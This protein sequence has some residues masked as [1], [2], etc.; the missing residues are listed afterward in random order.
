M[1]YF[2]RLNRKRKR[3][4]NRLLLLTE[5]LSL[6]FQLDAFAT[7]ALKKEVDRM[8]REWVH[9][10]EDLGKTLLLNYLLSCLLKIFKYHSET[11]TASRRCV[12]LKFEQPTWESADIKFKDSTYYLVEICKTRIQQMSR[13]KNKIS[14]QNGSLLR[15]LFFCRN[16]NDVMLHKNVKQ[17]L[18]RRILLFY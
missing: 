18:Q 16:A 8:R 17:Y 1:F 12:V 4:S 6:Y 5:N 14:I 11:S 15:Y 10:K 7:P 3:H 13:C 9:S 2:S